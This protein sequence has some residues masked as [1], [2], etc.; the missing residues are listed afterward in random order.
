MLYAKGKPPKKYT[1]FLEC[2]E[3]DVIARGYNGDFQTVWKF[4][5]MHNWLPLSSYTSAR[6]EPRKNLYGWDVLSATQVFDKF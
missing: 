3:N 2:L 5:P 1:Y 6:G 4:H